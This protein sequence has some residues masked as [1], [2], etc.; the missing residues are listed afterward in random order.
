MGNVVPANRELI[1]ALQEA[2]DHLTHLIA[3]SDRLPSRDEITERNYQRA[4]E[5]VAM[6]NDALAKAKAES[7]RER[8]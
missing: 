7:G 2:A 8:A 5:I 4:V 1:M 6:A 3:L